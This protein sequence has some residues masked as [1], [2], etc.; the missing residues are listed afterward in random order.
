MYA[1]NQNIT[2]V[3]KELL[4]QYSRPRNPTKCSQGGFSVEDF[5]LEK[6]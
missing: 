3:S 6:E 1:K 2:S 5:L 4:E